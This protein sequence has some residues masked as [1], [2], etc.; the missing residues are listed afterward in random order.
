RER[1]RA[2]VHDE[3]RVDD[4]GVDV[5]FRRAL[6]CRHG[7]ADAARLIDRERRNAK[8]AA[9]LRRRQRE[10]DIL[11]HVAIEWRRQLHGVDL[12]DLV[13]AV[14]DHQ[15]NRGDAFAR[16]LY[17]HRVG[18]LALAGYGLLDAW[19]CRARWTDE[20]RDRRGRSRLA[21]DVYRARGDRQLAAN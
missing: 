5:A 17:E 21:I 6:C 1:E 19:L 8:L 20:R 9:L 4:R 7:V 13:R 14:A 2:A 12:N 3:R 16:R 11:L 15:A 18:E 10:R